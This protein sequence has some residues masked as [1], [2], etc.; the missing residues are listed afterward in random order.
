MIEEFPIWRS[1][2]S[3]YSFYGKDKF[4]GLTKSQQFK[5]YVQNDGGMLYNTKC[6]VRM[7]SALPKEG[8][9]IWKSNIKE[10][11]CIPSGSP[12]LQDLEVW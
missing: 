2:V 4:I 8:I 3:D 6:L 10:K 1:F 11:S 12:F 7:T 5:F 9:S